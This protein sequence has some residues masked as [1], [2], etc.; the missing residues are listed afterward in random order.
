M[1]E[2]LAWSLYKEVTNGTGDI[3]LGEL[4]A[5]SID[6]LDIKQVSQS[7][8]RSQVGTVLQDNMLFNVSIRE[9]IRLGKPD[10][11]G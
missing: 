8:L 10:A 11:T 9:N 5:V 2:I 6:G 4:G 3:H 1:E 7:S